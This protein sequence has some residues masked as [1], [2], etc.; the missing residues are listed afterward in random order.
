MTRFGDG[1]AGAP[2]RD[3]RCQASRLGARRPG[4]AVL[5]LAGAFAAIGSR[6]LA[7]PAASGGWLAFLTQQSLHDKDAALAALGLL[8]LAGG[9]ILAVALVM[10]DILARWLGVDPPQRG[11]ERRTL[12]SDHGP[13]R[14]R[15]ARRR[16]EEP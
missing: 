1:Q 7:D 3:P 13:L 6:T 9:T 14:N 16:R 2:Q 10:V 15:S 12:G 8:G 4:S 5:L 11:P